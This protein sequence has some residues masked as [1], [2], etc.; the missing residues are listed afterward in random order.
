MDVSRLFTPEFHAD[1]YPVYR[2]MREESHILELDGMDSFI[3]T[4]FEEVQGILRD[5]RFLSSA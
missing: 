3:A 2:E 4:G 1:P 5:T